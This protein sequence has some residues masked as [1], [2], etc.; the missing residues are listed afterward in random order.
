MKNIFM[1]ITLLALLL[2]CESASL[3]NPAYT[4]DDLTVINATNYPLDIRIT[5]DNAYA[6]I[7]I[8]PFDTVVIPEV[9][10]NIKLKESNIDFSCTDRK[11][12]Q[13]FLNENVIVSID[14]DNI[15]TFNIEK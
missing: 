14:S 15:L 13:S 4:K 8:D 11:L 2:S 10:D 6:G 9:L 12:E 7:S 5:A 3:Y 1:S